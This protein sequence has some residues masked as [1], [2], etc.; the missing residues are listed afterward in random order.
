[1]I[2]KQQSCHCAV[3]WYDGGDFT[4]SGGV[5][6]A[7]RGEYCTTGIILSIGMMVGRLNSQGV[8]P[9]HEEVSIEQQSCYC[10]SLSI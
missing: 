3:Y 7:R 6:V 4:H 1:M 8:L 10:F 5:L 2:T 9:L